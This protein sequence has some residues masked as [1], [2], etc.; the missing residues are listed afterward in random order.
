ML[1]RSR[2]YSIFFNKCPKCHQGDFFEVKNPYNLEKF[3]KMNKECSECSESFTRETGFY[4][5]AMY[6]S[7]G[8]TV[9]FGLFLFALMVVFFDLDVWAFLITFSLA[10]ILFMPVIYRISRL[11]WINIFVGPKK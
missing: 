3:S 2:L 9:F 4:Y 7:Y 1:K 5:G 10:I 6:A 8:I 11:I